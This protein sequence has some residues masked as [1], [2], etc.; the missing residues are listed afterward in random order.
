MQDKALTTAPKVN[1][2]QLVPG[3]K[4]PRLPKIAALLRFIALDQVL[5]NQTDG[6]PKAYRAYDG[7]DACSMPDVR[8]LL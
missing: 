6:S 4:L 2:C 1:W 3:F 5:G 8:K 7:D